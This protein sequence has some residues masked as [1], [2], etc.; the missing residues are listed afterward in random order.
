M[1]AF[2]PLSALLLSPAQRLDTT[3]SHTGDIGHRFGMTSSS[4]KP[5]CHCAGRSGSLPQTSEAFAVVKGGGT[6]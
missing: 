3:D 5:T 4:A 2:L 1:Q 6:E